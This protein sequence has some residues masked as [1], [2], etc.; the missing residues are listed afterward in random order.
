MP[1][2]SAL[3]RSIDQVQVRLAD[4]AEQAQTL[5]AADLAHR[6]HNLVALLLQQRQIGAVNLD[7][8]LALHA[9]DGFFHVVGNRLRE[10]PGDSG[11]LLGF[12]AQRFDQ[13]VFVLMKQRTPLVFRLQIDK[14]FGVEEARGI[15]AVV[16]PAHLAHHLRHFRKLGEHHPRV[17][18]DPSPFRR[19]RAGRKRPARPD[20]ALIQMRQ[21]FR[22]DVARQQQ[23]RPPE[24][25]SATPTVIQRQRIARSSPHA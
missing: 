18:H 16:G 24:L 14:I 20:R 3:A 6:R 7:R 11:K 12:L 10:I 21:E 25:A 23:L 2:R 13:L 9:A 4:D 8:Q 15:G 1:K 19:T 5:D 22:A 17:V